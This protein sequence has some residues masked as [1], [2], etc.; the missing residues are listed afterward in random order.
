MADH[1]ITFDEKVKGWTSFH[2][3][4]PEY[5]ADM[6]SKFYTF[7]N[8]QLYLHN[9]ETGDR[10]TF[11]GTRGDSVIEFSMNESPSD[12]KNIKAIALES[13][14][15]TWDA[16]IETN[17]EKGH[18]NKESFEDKEGFSYG[19]IR[20]DSNAAVDT[21][22]LSVV[23]IGEITSTP[24][25]GAYFFSKVPSQINTIEEGSGTGD[26]LYFLNSED[27]Q[28]KIGTIESKTATGLTVDFVENSPSVGD[29]CFAVKDSI[30]ESFSLKGYFA[31]IKLT[32]EST[33]PCE[34]FAVNTE[35]DKSFP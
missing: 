20:R 33:D 31:K 28:K 32:S 25:I 7:K 23:G 14:N 15:K 6:N 34:L 21:A 29:F 5:I 12:V 18:V 10:N 26:V 1:T 35:I 9:K 16:T 17:L 27:E 8:G 11:Y 2:T 30:A 3:Y 4:Y 19:Y 24:G 22:L 13:N